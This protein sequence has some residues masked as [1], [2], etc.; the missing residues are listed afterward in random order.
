VSCGIFIL[1]TI[2]KSCNS[3]TSYVRVSCIQQSKI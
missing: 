3:H 2:L 1:N